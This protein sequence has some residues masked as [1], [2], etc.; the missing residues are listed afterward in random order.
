MAIDDSA[1]ILDAISDFCYLQ[2]VDCEIINQGLQGLFKIQKKEYD[3]ILLD[4]AM[5]EYTGFD[6]LDQLKKQGVR[7]KNVVVMTATNLKKEDF[8]DYGEVS[9]KE[10][11]HKPVKLSQL[12]KIIK[13]YQ[14][15]PSKTYLPNM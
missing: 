3:L 2:N 4:I 9:V 7:G 12:E 1:D 6:I 10:V 13:K 14:W 8:V 11:L 15:N 5:P